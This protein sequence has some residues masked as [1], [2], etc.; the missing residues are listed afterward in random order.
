MD[1]KIASDEAATICEDR[2]LALGARSCA[3]SE[4]NML[5]TCAQASAYDLE[6][7]KVAIVSAIQALLRVG[8]GQ[9]ARDLKR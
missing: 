2:A 5:R 3:L 8:A 9:G 6:T 7:S 4:A 1:L